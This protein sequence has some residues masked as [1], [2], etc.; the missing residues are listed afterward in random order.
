MDAQVYRVPPA[1]V[2]QYDYCIMFPLSFS[3]GSPTSSE[4]G[5]NPN[6]SNNNSP[7][8][9]LN[10][11]NSGRFS[12]Q[13]SK[14][15]GRDAKPVDDVEAQQDSNLTDNNADQFDANIKDNEDGR[16]SLSSEIPLG[17][18]NNYNYDSNRDALSYDA[19]V[20]ESVYYTFSVSDEAKEYI[21]RIVTIFGRYYVYQYDNIDNLFRI[22]L[23]RGSVTRMK[24]KA[25][26]AKYKMLLDEQVIKGVLLEGDKHYD[27]EPIYIPHNPLST[28]IGPFQYIYTRYRENDDL[29]EYYWRYDI[30]ISTF[31]G[32][33][34]SQ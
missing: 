5:Q 19:L 26:K 18:T 17:A 32:Y 22:V 20:H 13:S 27:I 34:M 6:N 30:D 31:S 11:A 16:N 1:Q 10:D 25:E 29:Q 28:K 24:V 4:R 12:P 14:N 7:K 21:S 2:E 8:S 33:L 9:R 3:T 15:N 23:I